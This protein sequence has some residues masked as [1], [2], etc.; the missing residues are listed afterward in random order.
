MGLNFALPFVFAV[1]GWMITGFASM[2]LRRVDYM[3]PILLRPDVR[4]VGFLIASGG[5]I[6]AFL[7]SRWWWGLGVLVASP[8]FAAVFIMMLT[9]RR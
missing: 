8:N 5:I 2:A 4:A 7:F 3:N 1:L 9:P 6:S